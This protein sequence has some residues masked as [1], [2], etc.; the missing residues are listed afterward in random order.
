MEKKRVSM[1]VSPELHQLIG[2]LAQEADISRTDVI[3]KAL[4]VMK[5]YREQKKH[6]RTHIGFTAD[7]SRLDAEILDVL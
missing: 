3:R 2:E 6:G 5:A 4:S 1:Q 7:A